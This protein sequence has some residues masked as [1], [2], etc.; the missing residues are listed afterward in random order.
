[1]DVVT[2]LL[3]FFVLLYV[4]TPGIDQAS[5]ETFVS[6][7]RGSKSILEQTSPA[8][9]EALEQDL[10]RERIREQLEAFERFLQ[11]QGHASLV[12]V[13]MTA[14]GIKV[15]LSDEL[16]FD[17]GSAQLLPAAR[18]VLREFALSL[19]EDIT[20]IEVQGHTDNVPLSRG[21]IYD[22]NWHLGAARSVSVIYFLQ[23]QTPFDPRTF[24]ATSF[25]EYRPIAD[26]RTA[27]G[28]RQNRRVE[29]YVR[30]SSLTETVDFSDPA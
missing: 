29:I 22:S 15:T 18:H 8:S 19:N 17:S 20:E 9:M 21:S 4:L 3:V 30:L 11:R 10:T 5:F 24:R 25:G 6:H 26:N 7:F 16:T 28:R 12:E 2:L 14:D 23:E 27:E 1:M 13:S